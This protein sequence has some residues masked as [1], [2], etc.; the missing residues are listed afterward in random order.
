MTEAQTIQ[1]LQAVGGILER[2]KNNKTRRNRFECRVPRPSFKS[3][4]YLVKKRDRFL[5]FKWERRKGLACGVSIRVARNR[6]STGHQHHYLTLG[7]EGA[8]E[9]FLPLLKSRKLKKRDLATKNE[10]DP[11]KIDTTASSW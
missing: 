2:N 7:E 8:E 5:V 4:I 9:Q 6:Q 3:S 11:V 1:H 10:E